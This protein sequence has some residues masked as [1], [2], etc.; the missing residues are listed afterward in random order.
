M[1]KSRQ[2][3]LVI[4]QSEHQKL[5]AAT[6]ARGSIQPAPPRSYKPSAARSTAAMRCSSRAST[7][8]APARQP[9]AQVISAL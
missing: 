3:P 4:P 6:S 5:A 8:A 2:R 7:R 1:F 9:S